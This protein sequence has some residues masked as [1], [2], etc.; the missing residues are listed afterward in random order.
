M[1]S[2]AI[3]ALDYIMHPSLYFYYTSIGYKKPVGKWSEKILQ[4]RNYRFINRFTTCWVPDMQGEI[5]WPLNYPNAEKKPNIPVKYI[6][7]LSRFDPYD[8]PAGGDGDK[9]HLLII[10]SGPEPQRQYPGK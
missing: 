8:T 5:I 4:K 9:D 1:R 10:L 3:T 6:G 2:S 7:L